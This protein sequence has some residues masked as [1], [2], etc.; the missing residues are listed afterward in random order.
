MMKPPPPR[1][2]QDAI[3]TAGIDVLHLEDDDLYADLVKMW[4][5]GHGLT[6]RRVR[7]RAELLRDLAICAPPPRCLLLDLSL[8]DSQGLTLCDELKKSPSLQH[9]PIVGRA[10]GVTP[11]ND[12]A[13]LQWVIS[14]CACAVAC[15]NLSV[16][17][18]EPPDS[19][20]R[21]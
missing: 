10:A 21:G 11:F 7:S 9:L 17:A 16:A 8:Q 3:S 13:G 5:T 20:G 6:L 15:N 19:N 2:A 12:H 18:V 4:I 1:H 14:W